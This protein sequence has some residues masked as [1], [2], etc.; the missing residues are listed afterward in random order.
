MKTIN[1]RYYVIAVLFCLVLA[2]FPAWAQPPLSNTDGCMGYP[3]GTHVNSVK[4]ITKVGSYY[5]KSIQL[6]QQIPDGN[7]AFA[8][9]WRLLFWNDLLIGAK[10]RVEG[11]E[12]KGLWEQVKNDLGTTFGTPADSYEGTAY[13]DA[14]WDSAQTF[15]RVEYGSSTGVKSVLASKEIYDKWVQADKAMDRNKNLT[16]N[17]SRYGYGNFSKYCV[18]RSTIEKLPDGIIR[19]DVYSVSMV[20]DDIASRTTIE[21]NCNEHTLRFTNRVYYRNDQI[22]EQRMKRESKNTTESDWKP[23]KGIYVGIC[24]FLCK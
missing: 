9:Q 18:D 12:L 16:C 21:C 10:L 7:N 20:E 6:Y 1:R 23:A 13:K 17:Y 11:K 15:A 4:N 19:A 24:T 22:D 8:T 2:V 14:S 5:D 3:W